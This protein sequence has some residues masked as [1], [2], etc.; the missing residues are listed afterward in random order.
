M[1]CFWSAAQRHRI[2]PAPPA[3]KDFCPHRADLRGPRRARGLAR[4][5]RIG[6]ASARRGTSRRPIGNNP[7]RANGRNSLAPALI[8]TGDP[9]CR[10]FFGS[11]T[12]ILEVVCIVHAFKTGRLFPWLFVIIFLPLVGCIAY[13]FVEILPGMMNS[14]RACPRFM[15]QGLSKLSDPDKDLRAR[16]REVEMV[17]SADAKRGLAEEYM[18]RG[19]VMAGRGR[20]LSRCCVRHA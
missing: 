16:K 9:L 1:F 2:G 17:G 11:A 6:V 15:Q 18:R 3:P 4:R 7:P 20:T 5:A 8:I 19:M 10:I 13:F 14:R 12:L